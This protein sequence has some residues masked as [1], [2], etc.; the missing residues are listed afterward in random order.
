MFE[1]VFFNVCLI[2]NH[3][4]SEGEIALLLK[5][6]PCKCDEFDSAGPMCHSYV[7][8]VVIIRHHQGNL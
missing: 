5:C 3:V 7:S 2:E 6:L 4:P 1:Y 8:I